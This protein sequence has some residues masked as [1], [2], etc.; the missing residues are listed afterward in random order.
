MKPETIKIDFA[1]R[2]GA[3]CET[4]AFALDE[5]RVE[6]RE[7]GKG[8]RI[9]GHAAVFDLLSEDL[10]GFR[11]KISPGAFAEAISTDDVRALFNHD[12]NLLLGRNRANTLMLS[13]DEKGLRSVIDLPD[14][15]VARDLAVLMQ[16]GDV[17]QMSFA[18][19]ISK[20]GQD[21]ERTGEGP[22]I[23]TIN[24]IKR[25]WD[26]S[27]V[28]YPAY[29]QTDAA[30]RALRAV[31]ETMLAATRATGETEQAALAQAKLAEAAGAERAHLVQRHRLRLIDQGL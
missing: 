8:Q 19:A 5:V 7:D 23:R 20:D 1:R 24:K 3:D 31:E 30:V 6:A 26:V 17:N 15:Q 18:F 11:E 21:W 29:P 27:V 4:R 9:V 10:G 13:E 2:H 14:T 22:W 16:R 12:D 28:T 25:L